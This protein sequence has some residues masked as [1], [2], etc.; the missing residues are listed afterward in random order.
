M[1]LCATKGRNPFCP[2][3]ATRT[4]TPD[5]IVTKVDHDTKT[6]TLE[7]DDHQTHVRLQAPTMSF[8]EWK[9]R[10]DHKPQ[11]SLTER[12]A[13]AAGRKH[14]SDGAKAITRAI[15]QLCMAK[16]FD[17]T[18]SLMIDALSSP[19]DPFS[20]RVVNLCKAHLH[21]LAGSY[22]QAK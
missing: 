16:G 14:L 19:G 7:P 17:E 11:E 13:R 21:A 20:R 10:P 5:L 6:V 3:C 18:V 22:E 15:E 8:E 1:C 12:I 9:A 4:E 2:D